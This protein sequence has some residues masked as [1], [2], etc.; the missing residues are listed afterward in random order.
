MKISLV[1]YAKQHLK[2]KQTQERKRDYC[3]LKCAITHVV[4]LVRDET[5]SSKISCHTKSWM[6]VRSSLKD[7]RQSIVASKK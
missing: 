2:Q 5:Q 3:W 1:I 6:I 7:I 4:L